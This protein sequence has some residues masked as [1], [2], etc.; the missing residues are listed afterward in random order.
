MLRLIV[1]IALLLLPVPVQAGPW[2]R[3]KGSGFSSSSFAITP[4]RDTATQTY[5]EYGFSDAMTLG[6]DLNYFR[7]GN[8]AQGGIATVFIRRALGAPERTSKWAYEVGL[9]ATWGAMAVNPH[10]DTGLSWGRGITFR[11]KS[12]WAT[13]DASVLWDLSG[14]RHVAKL[15]GTLGL[16]F[17]DRY[18]AMMQ[19]FYV[20][21]QGASATTLAPSLIISP[22]D[23]K[24]RIQVGAE[25]A[26]GDLTGSALKI[27]LWRDF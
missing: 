27:G 13:V 2:L 24:F 12:G 8:G 18:G 25:A 15:D 14:H 11:E 5:L 23:S 22:K 6:V 9:G 26:L 19:I 10:L 3:E 7:P 16:N 17:T 1:F 21:A 20:H 4:M